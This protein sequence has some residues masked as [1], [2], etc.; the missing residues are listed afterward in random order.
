M[1]GRCHV[2]RRS[3][4][5]ERHLLGSCFEPVATIF[6]ARLGNGRWSFK[7]G[8]VWRELALQ[9]RFASVVTRTPKIC[10]F[11]FLNLSDRCATRDM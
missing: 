3:F 2:R 5:F 6:N 1:R 8:V 11:A 9:R 4:V 10:R 7:T